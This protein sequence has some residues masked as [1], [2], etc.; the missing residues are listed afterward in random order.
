MDEKK[1]ECRG[2]SAPITYVPASPQPAVYCRECGSLA[3][4]DP[5]LSAPDRPA[6][7]APRQLPAPTPVPAVT[8]APS[9]RPP[10]AVRVRPRW[11]FAVAG[12]L[13]V[14]FVLVMLVL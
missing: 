4:G 14:S 13:L 10:T 8:P 2:C 12:G 9:D 11:L 3:L 7:D 1:I 5:S 6:R